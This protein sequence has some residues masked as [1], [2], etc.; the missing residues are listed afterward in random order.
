M[1]A[2]PPDETI[3]SLALRD[4]STAQRCAAFSPRR[5]RSSL[6]PVKVTPA[7]RSARSR[8]PSS[9]SEPADENE[10]IEAM[11]TP[12]P[13]SLA[14][15]KYTD[16]L[17][18]ASPSLRKANLSSPLVPLGTPLRSALKPRRDGNRAVRSPARPSQLSKVTFESPIESPTLDQTTGASPAEPLESPSKGSRFV[19]VTSRRT[20]GGS[21]EKGKQR[22]RKN[23]A[24]LDDSSSSEEREASQ[25]EGIVAPRLATPRTLPAHL[26]PQTPSAYRFSPSTPSVRPHASYSDDELTDC[27]A[28]YSVYD[29]N[30]VL[31]S[32]PAGSFDAVVL[33]SS[34][35]DDERAGAVDAFE[36]DVEREDEVVPE[37]DG[38]SIADES[39]TEAEEDDEPAS[40][41]DDGERS[42]ALIP[43][44]LDANVPEEDVGGSFK[45]LTLEDGSEDAEPVTSEEDEP[46]AV[47]DADE[48]EALEEQAPPHVSQED[49]PNDEDVAE[50]VAEDVVEEVAVDAAEL[51]EGESADGHDEETSVREELEEYETHAGGQGAVPYDIE[52]DEVETSQT[53]E[54]KADQVK[55]DPIEVDQVRA[56]QGE[57]KQVEP[58]QHLASA[59]SPTTGEPAN[60]PASPELEPPPQGPVERAPPSPFLDNAAFATPLKA[61]V[62]EVTSR[63]LPV[64]HLT[65]QRHVLHGLPPSVPAATPARVAAPSLRP[66]QQQQVHDAPTAR[67]QL[68]KISSLATKRSL[69]AINETQRRTPLTSISSL[70]PPAESRIIGPPRN[71]ETPSAALPRPVLSSTSRLV[72]PSSRVTSGA[73]PQLSTVDENRPPTTSMRP[74]ASTIPRPR[75]LTKSGLRPPSANVARSTQPNATNSSAPSSATL[76][77]AS[78]RSTVSS[79]KPSRTIPA[80]STRSTPMA[81]P[82]SNHSRVPLSDN[83][84]SSDGPGARPIARSNF[85]PAPVFRPF[86]SLGQT[87]SAP[88]LLTGRTPVLIAGPPVPRSARPVKP[89]PAPVEAISIEPVPT[90]ASPTK[91]CSQSQR[92]AEEKNTL[93]SSPSRETTTPPPLLASPPR[94][95]AGGSLAVASTLS[96]QLP[97]SPPRATSPP[98]FPSSSPPRR[99]VPP[100]PLRSPRR[101][102][103]EQAYPQARAPP[104]QPLSVGP[105]SALVVPAEK[106]AGVSSTLDLFARPT[107]PEAR[108]AAV[109]IRSTRPRRTRAVQ[110]EVAAPVQLPAKRVTRRTTATGTIAPAP[111]TVPT[112]PLIPRSSRRPPKQPAVAVVDETDDSASSTTT[113]TEEGGVV[114]P[115]QT[116]PPAPVYH[117]NAA[118]VVTQ[119]E[120]NRLTQ[121]NTKKN[122]Q[123]FNKI[124]VETVYLEENRPPSPTSKIRK[125]FGSEGSLGRQATKEGREARAAKR[126]NALRSS[127]DGSASGIGDEGSAN[128]SLDGED[129]SS[130]R[131]VAHYRAPGDDEQYCTPARPAR[132]KVG[133]KKKSSSSSSPITT[134]A[135]KYVKWDKAL[136]YEGPRGETTV[137]QEGCPGILRHT[138]LDMWGNSTETS[139]NFAKPSPVVIR[140]RVF[141]DDEDA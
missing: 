63:V 36:A 121:R 98:A 58:G 14:V 137:A 76:P 73:E 49:S 72:P 31:L 8:T 70:R 78:A 127:L 119:E 2:V 34:E 108:P 19:T 141:K 40:A 115:T 88:S 50:D 21:A 105:A 93:A 135:R 129:G 61:V 51:I 54:S 25:V 10:L 102:P 82:V 110:E 91:R 86:P 131:P 116:V 139:T 90:L 27:D 77:V 95:S 134:S 79:S 120:L 45:V 117:F 138:E 56:S 104:P 113:A 44:T 42:D 18:D 52:N 28:D 89:A 33:G 64:V 29:E 22:R 124:K 74:P 122:Q 15:P 13:T 23:S 53:E 128:A 1:A 112:G 125:S 68:T 5:T 7:R 123:A 126:R 65:P 30:D 85:P 99:V 140:K 57:A 62:E 55:I 80:P 69:E 71:L 47:E 38:L 94:V 66:S 17:L 81:A 103:L 9:A 136:V 118:P 101:V 26:L 97:P 43:V 37:N 114:N 32:R 59:I 67:R 24:E 132:S 133:S 92:L 4:H 6:S 84:S 75:V 109:P 16:S 3:V 48:P 11:H 35:G 46:E 20:R 39:E 41:S 130:P 87:S 12:A 60:R 106:L 100:S 111:P 96:V 107:V 83:L